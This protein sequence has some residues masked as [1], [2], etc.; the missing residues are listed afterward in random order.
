MIIG[1]FR[2]TL[3]GKQSD[4]NPDTSRLSNVPSGLPTQGARQLFL[5]AFDVRFGSEPEVAAYRVLAAVSTSV[6]MRAQY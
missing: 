3:S 1:E 2:P 4:E 5:E 6:L